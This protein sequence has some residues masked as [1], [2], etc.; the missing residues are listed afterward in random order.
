MSPRELLSA[1]NRIVDRGAV[2]TALRVL[3]NCSPIFWYA[4]VTSRAE[5]NPALALRAALP[6]VKSA[7]H[8][9]ITDPTV[10]GALLRARMSERGKRRCIYHGGCSTGPRTIEG[11]ARVALN[12]PRL[13]CPIASGQLGGGSMARSAGAIRVVGTA[14][15]DA[16]KKNPGVNSLHQ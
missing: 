16:I 7:H 5:T 2:E 9:A 12:L 11:K 1:I 8:A 13:R 10:L 6:P 4:I 15:H 3:Q 14:D